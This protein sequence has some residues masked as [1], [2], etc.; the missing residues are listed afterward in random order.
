MAGLIDFYKVYRAFVRG[1][2]ESFRLNDAGINP[3]EQDAARQRATR[4]FRLARGYIERRRLPPCLYITCGL[5]GA[6]KSSL[7]DQ[8]SFELGFPCFRSDTVR[9]Q[10]AGL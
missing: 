7:A 2:V 9:K 8:L 4:Y 10:I 1:K 6:G 3:A 5:M